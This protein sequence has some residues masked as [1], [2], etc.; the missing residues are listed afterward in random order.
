MAAM[1]EAAGL[2]FPIINKI[3]GDRQASGSALVEND[4]H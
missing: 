2:G 1:A 4:S 3:G